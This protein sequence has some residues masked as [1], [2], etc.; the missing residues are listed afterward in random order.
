[1]ISLPWWRTP[2]LRPVSGVLAVLVVLGLLVAMDRVVRH[3]MEQGEL[4]RRALA[5]QAEAT[6][7]CNTLRGAG[8]REAC[9]ARARAGARPT[10]PRATGVA[11]N[12]P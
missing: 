5:L 1:M 4:H 9:L 11:G 8:Q 7:R 6:W 3:A 10:G 2:P 12:A